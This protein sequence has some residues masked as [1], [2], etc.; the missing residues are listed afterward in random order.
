MQIFS[1]DNFHAML[2]LIYLFFSY[3]KKSKKYFINLMS[4]EFPHRLLKCDNDS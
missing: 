1:W 3:E 4:A 2:N